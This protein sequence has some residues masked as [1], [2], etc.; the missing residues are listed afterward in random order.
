MMKKIG[1]NDPCPCGSGKKYKRCCQGLAAATND[2]LSEVLAG[3]DFNSR[4]DMQAFIDVFMQQKNNQPI[5]DF[6]GLSSEQVHRLLHFPFDSP[7]L[8]LFS[9]RV[10]HEIEAPVLSLVRYIVEAIDDKGLKLTARGNLPQKLC[11]EAAKDFL[12]SIPE[13]DIFHRM[14]VNK[15]EDFFDLHVA[16]LLLELAGFLRKSKGRLFLTKKYQSQAAGVGVV[17]IYPTL[18]QYYCQTF[19][20]GYWDHHE[21]INFIQQ[22]ALFSLYLLKR[23]GDHWQPFSLY[24]DGFIQAFPAVLVGVEESAYWSAEDTVRHCYS[25]RALERFLVYFGLAE[26]EK[27][28]RER[29]FAYDFRIRALPLLD[30]VLQFV[31]L[32]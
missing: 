20:W 21:D 23:Y 12:G 19:N 1:R 5:D 27:I 3:K 28:R 15:E 18:L 7:D 29:P 24:E 9:E 4:E 14:R 26:V 17:G 13:D 31:F 25:M 22:S 10:A 32:H 11:K 2:E 8:F 16:R 6:Q 30:E